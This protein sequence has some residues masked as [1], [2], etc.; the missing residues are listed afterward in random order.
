MEL[1]EAICSLSHKGRPSIVAQSKGNILKEAE[2]GLREGEIE[3]DRNR[4]RQRARALTT[5]FE[6]QSSLFLKPKSPLDL[7]SIGSQ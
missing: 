5:S 7:P 1:S 3:T 6:T 2:Q 4:Q